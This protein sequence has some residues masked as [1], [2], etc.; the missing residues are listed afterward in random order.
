MGTNYFAVINRPSTREP[1]HI[2]KSSGG[3]RFHFHQ[4]N[5]EWY[6]PPIH[7]NTYEQVRDWLKA[8]TVDSKD[9]VIMNEYDEIVSFDDFIE[10]VQAKQAENNPEDFDYYCRNVNGY[11]FD[12]QWFR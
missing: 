2:G 12:D 9:W 1:L 3:W 6:D 7:W 5:D 10:L 8:N 4:I 11:R